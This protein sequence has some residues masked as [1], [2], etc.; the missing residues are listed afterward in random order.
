MRKIV[1]TYGL[2]SAA[3]SA[4]MWTIISLTM[5]HSANFNGAMFIGYTSMLL[6]IFVVYFAM[7]NY[8]NNVGGGEIKFGKAFLLGLY[9]SIIYAV[10]YVVVWMI[11]RQTIMTDFVDKYIAWQ[12]EELQSANLSPEIMKQKLT[13][14]EDAKAIFAN[15]WKEAAF[16]FT[17]P[18]PVA[19]IVTLVSAFIVSRK[20]KKQELAVA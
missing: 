9:I 16:V 18:W 4:V 13:E 14:M 2:I 10:F 12:M 6:S 11:L 3:I 8:K 1:I 15:P 17:E 5:F 19:I 7:K 20:K